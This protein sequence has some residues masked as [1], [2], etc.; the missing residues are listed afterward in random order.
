MNTPTNNKENEKSLWRYIPAHEFQAPSDTVS[1]AVKGGLAG[2]WNR[3]TSKPKNPTQPVKTRDSLEILSDRLEQQIAP[4]PNLQ[5]AASALNETLSPWIDGQR[6]WKTAIPVVAPPNSGNIAILERLAEKRRWRI[7]PPPKPAEILGSS[8][9]WLSDLTEN[10]SPWVLPNLEKCYLRHPAGLKPLRTLFAMLR[11]AR[12]GPGIIGCDSWA[13]AY[14]R[15]S[16]F[17]RLSR[18]WTAAPF[19]RPRLTQWLTHLASWDRGKRVSFRQADN[20]ALVLPPA[21][22]PEKNTDE[23]GET[24]EFITHLAAYSRGNPGIAWALW[25]SALRS[26]PDEKMASDVARAPHQVGEKTIWI[27]PWRRLKR[28]GP[29]SHLQTDPVLILHALLLHGGLSSNLL[30]TLVPL[31][32]NALARSLDELEQAEWIVRKDEEWRVTPLA[33]PEIRRAISDAGYLTD[34][35]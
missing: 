33:Y 14:F 6:P 21:L 16:A 12:L 34:D 22:E 15:H 26:A 8:E 27:V 25:R 31:S 7:I 19:D 3:M 35:F 32:Y 20:G 4:F 11:E 18:P 28:S 30:A 17:G 13:W 23:H 2:L 24:T 9:R 1:E 5:G 10:E 29:A